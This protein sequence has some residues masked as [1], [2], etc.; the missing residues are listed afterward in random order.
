MHP[1]KINKIESLYKIINKQDYIKL[2]S[3]LH[4]KRNSERNENATYQSRE[5]SA[6]CGQRM[7]SAIAVNRGCCSHQASSHCTCSQKGTQSGIQDR[8]PEFI[9][10]HIKE[11][12]SISLDLC[13]F[14]LPGSTVVKN[15]NLK[16]GRG[17]RHFQKEGIQRANRYM[18]RCSVSLSLREMQI[19]I[20]MRYDFT[21]A[22]TAIFNKTK[23]NKCC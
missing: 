7:Q 20:T 17:T 18:K 11:I 15:S 9:K 10:M 23:D 6:R 14:P 19:K 16:M 22:R 3:S 21:P 2:K 5:V 4:S 1:T 13:V 12:I 8:I